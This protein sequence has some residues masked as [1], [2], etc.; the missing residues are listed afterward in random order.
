MKMFISPKEKVRRYAKL[1]ADILF[2]YTHKEW[3]AVN[4]STTGESD[5]VWKR[6]RKKQ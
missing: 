5:R 2:V 4:L 1:G 6:K 3:E